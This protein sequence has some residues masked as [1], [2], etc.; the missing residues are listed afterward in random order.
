MVVK[1]RD[2]LEQHRRHRMIRMLRDVAARVREWH[3]HEE[4]EEDSEPVDPLDPEEIEAQM[5]AEAAKEHALAA[6]YNKSVSGTHLMQQIR[7]SMV[8]GV[9]RKPPP[10]YLQLYKDRE[11]NP[12][13]RELPQSSSAI[14]HNLPPFYL[15]NV[16]H[17]T[18]LAHRLHL[19]LLIRLFHLPRIDP[20]GFLS[21][22]RGDIRSGGEAS[23]NILPYG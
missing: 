20:Y 17:L 9:F 2:V 23:P 16:T 15:P 21:P 12:E 14:E 5:L 1:E 8:K 22:F 11:A 3:T 4:Q 13:P 7:A 18:H 10:E 19:A 6:A